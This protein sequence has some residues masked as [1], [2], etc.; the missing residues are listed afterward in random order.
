[1]T[2]ESAVGGRP[3]VLPRIIGQAWIYGT[4]ELRLDAQDPFARGFALS[5]AWGPQVD[6]LG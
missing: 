2:G 6:L 3:A 5:D 4:E 1:M